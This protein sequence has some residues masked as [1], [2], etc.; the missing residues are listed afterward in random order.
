MEEVRNERQ[1]L[2]M[3]ETSGSCTGDVPEVFFMGVGAS[4]KGNRPFLD[5]RRLEPNSAATR[6]WRCCAGPIEADIAG[7]EEE[8]PAAKEAH[9]VPVAPA[10]RAARYEHPIYVLGPKQNLLFFRRESNNE[11]PNYFFRGTAVAGPMFMTALSP[12]SALFC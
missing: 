9:G 6:V 11:P 2:V 10:N 7:C 5:K 4:A 8:E 3:Q 12:T 1:Q